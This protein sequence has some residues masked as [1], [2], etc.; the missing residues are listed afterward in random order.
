MSALSDVL[1]SLEIWLLVAIVLGWMFSRVAQQLRQSSPTLA[2]LLAISR[3][4][5]LDRD[6]PPTSASYRGELWAS[7]RVYDRTDCRCISATAGSVVLPRRL[8]KARIASA[9]NGRANRN[10]CPPSHS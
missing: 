6:A 4:E 7:V 5:R 10:P 9:S 2:E 8:R 1:L 3:A